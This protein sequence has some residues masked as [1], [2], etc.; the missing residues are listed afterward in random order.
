MF[1]A[2]QIRTLVSV[3]DVMPETLPWIEAM[4]EIKHNALAGLPFLQYELLSGILSGQTGRLHPIPMVGYEADA[5]W[6]L[7]IDQR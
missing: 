2:D 5:G 4:G 6:R 3:H 1:D 7:P